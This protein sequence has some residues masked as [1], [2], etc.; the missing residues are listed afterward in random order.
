M[1]VAYALFLVLFSAACYR[2]RGSGY[3]EHLPAHFLLFMRGDRLIKLAIGGFPVGVCS[4][5]AG[6]PLELALAVWALVA[7]TDTIPHASFQGAVNLLQM[8][9]M[10]AIG[11]ANAGAPAIAIYL[12]HRPTAAA[13]TLGLGTLMGP[14]YW[15]GNRTPLDYVSGKFA[16]REGPEVG[17]FYA[18]A[19]RAL[20]LPILL[21]TG[22]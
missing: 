9:G 5:Y 10:A 14:A 3:F 7:V 13:V 20:F 2:V 15:L 18:G 4:F 1:M 16:L 17:E 21:M 11:I 12:Q 19:A 6:V 22:L 8:L